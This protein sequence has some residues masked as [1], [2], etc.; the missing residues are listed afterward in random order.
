[1][2]Q[3]FEELWTLFLEGELD[4]V[5]LASL[6]QLLDTDSELLQRAGDLYEEHRLLGFALQPFDDERFVEAAV[7]TVE[8]DGQ[9]FVGDVIS[10]L[11]GRPSN[12][13]ARK[14]ATGW[15]RFFLAVA[16][17]VFILVSG[18]TWYFVNQIDDPASRSLVT[19]P[20]AKTEMPVRYVATMLLEDKCEWSSSES[21]TEGQRLSARSL[22]LKAGIAVIRFDGGAELVMTGETSLR[23]HSAGSA[24]LLFGDVVVRAEAGAEGFVLKTPTCEVIDLGTEFAVKV[25]RVGDTEVHVLDGQVSY[26]PIEAADELVRILQAGEGIAI[27]KDGRPRAVPMNPPRFQEFIRRVNPRTRSDLLTAYEGFN[28][29]PGILPLKESDVGIGWTGPWRKRVAS[30]RTRPYDAPS[31][32]HLEI[33]HGQMNVPWPVPGGR[34]GALKLTGGRVY[35]VRRLKTA[36]ELGR[37]DVTFLS[38]MVREMERADRDSDTKERLRLTFRSS[39]DYD[40]ELV[41]FGRDAKFRPVVSTGGGVWHTSPMTLP[42]GQTTLWIGKIISHKNG[43]DEI[44]FRVYGEEDALEYAEP[45]TWHVVTRDVDLDAR[46]DLV[47]LSSEG[48]TDRI[49]DELRIGPTWRSVTPI[50]GNEE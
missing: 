11:Q 23:L 3:Q 22:D 5:G 44:S 15:Q 31:P 35:Y 29:S 4:Q 32:D 39:Q 17:A 27:D 6:Q 26:R 47:L 13:A 18:L 2:S 42:T 49:I 33:V 20:I 25:N 34:L 16:V 14:E 43:D 1:M 36:I 38:M 30:E 37:E 41:S 12:V 48:T 50:M 21:P 45:S 8:N 19:E 46:L 28:Y 7:A 40:G 9:Q 10:E 24:G